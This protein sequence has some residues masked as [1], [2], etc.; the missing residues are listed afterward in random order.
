MAQDSSLKKETTLF[1]ASDG[2][3]EDSGLQD[4][5]AVAAKIR[6]EKDED[7]DAQSS[8]D[9]GVI[10]FSAG[11]LDV[12]AGLDDKKDE[13]EGLFGGFGTDLGLGVASAPL[14]DGD[15]DSLGGDGAVRE[16]RDVTSSVVAKPREESDEG[17]S[18]LTAI[19][20]V[21]GLA[22]VGAAAVFF[23]S[24]DDE[25]KTD[26][27]AV[28]SM[29]AKPEV[30]VVGK[31]EP[32]PGQA[33]GAVGA[34]GGQADDGLADE[35]AAEPT[36]EML[37]AEAAAAEGAA[38]E[39]GEFDADDPM[40][41]TAGLLESDDKPDTASSGGTWD[42][43]K[44]RSAG[45]SNSAG[46]NSAAAAPE[47]EPDP[48]PAVAPEPDPEPAPAPKSSG[49]DD[50]DVDCLLNPDL[51]KCQKSA[52][53]PK[54]EEQV[55]APK[56]PEK[57]SS[58]DLRNGFNKLKSKAKACGSQ[59]GA[60]A[61]TKVKVHVSIEGATGKVT[62]AEAKGEHAGTALGKCVE[63]VVEGATFDV[64]KKPAMGIDYSL[65]M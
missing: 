54:T 17:R 26:E 35:P 65:I 13:D 37:A 9:S 42:Q 56:I 15:L 36:P 30:A 47:P 34:G 33:V 22:L 60:A 5:L 28:A 45:G 41:R 46:S 12:D 24:G 63:G 19:A 53:K 49:S 62:S 2:E 25:V 40:A 55:L 7:E 4:I 43:G 38:V 6:D 3:R 10:V 57:L 51:A 58:T 64:F 48:E 21:F 18:P 8:E 20:V 23:A 50:D 52:S 59:H 44:S 14:E 16:T 1:P 27:Q 29:S 61:G 31:A 39:A 32:D 11:S